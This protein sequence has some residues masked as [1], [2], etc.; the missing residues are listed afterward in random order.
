[1]IDAEL[2]SQQAERKEVTLEL[3]QSIW[4]MYKDSIPPTRSSLR[5]QLT[6]MDMEFYPPDEVRII[7][8]DEM[9][10]SAANNERNTLIDLFRKES[11]NP[12]RV[13]VEL[14]KDMVIKEEGPKVLSKPEVLEEMKKKNPSLAKLCDAL[15]M[16][17][18][19]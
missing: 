18:E 10:E 19:W 5:S 6:M 14:R 12:L 17:I 7:C 11:E 13:R 15:N 3:V 9:I 2:K 4:Q 16:Q 1:V 8:K